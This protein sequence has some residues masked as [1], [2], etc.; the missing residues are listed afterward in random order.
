MKMVPSTRLGFSVAMIA[1]MAVFTG[2]SSNPYN[3]SFPAE[4]NSSWISRAEPITLGEPLVAFAWEQQ[5]PPVTKL[6]ALRKNP[7]PE[8]L[9]IAQNADQ[10]MNVIARNQNLHMRQLLDD[11]DLAW[12]QKH[13]IRLSMYPIP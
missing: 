13:P 9:T 8:L 3:E 12:L 1:A 11:W 7:S 5:V 4:R 10:R 2:C 6:G